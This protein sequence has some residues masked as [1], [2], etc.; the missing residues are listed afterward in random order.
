MFRTVGGTRAPGETPTGRR[1]TLV[2]AQSLGDWTGSQGVLF[3]AP[4]EEGLTAPLR[5]PRAR[6]QILYLVCNKT[7]ISSLWVSKQPELE[8][9]LK[10]RFGQAY[11]GD[12]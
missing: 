8:V 11:P 12:T 9:T 5:N 7:V 1:R 10:L 3:R 4:V 6:E 2:W